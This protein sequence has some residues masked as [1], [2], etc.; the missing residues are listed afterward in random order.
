MDKSFV[1]LEAYRVFVSF[2]SYAFL[3][4]S[5]TSDIIHVIN[6]WSNLVSSPCKEE[7]WVNDS[8]FHHE[9]AFTTAPTHCGRVYSYLNTKALKIKW[10]S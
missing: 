4:H 3:I 7:S 2:P 10:K 8:E 1:E 5:K 9:G 6:K